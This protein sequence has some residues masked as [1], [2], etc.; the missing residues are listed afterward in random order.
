MGTAG[1]A[2]YRLASGDVDSAEV[3]AQHALGVMPNDLLDGHT[4]DL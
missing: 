1:H 3:K 2:A 4:I